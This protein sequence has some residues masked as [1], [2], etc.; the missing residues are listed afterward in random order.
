[1]MCVGGQRGWHS[2]P[3]QPLGMDA[4][5]SLNFSAKFLVEV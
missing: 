1:M 5:P 4:V 3:S 2:V